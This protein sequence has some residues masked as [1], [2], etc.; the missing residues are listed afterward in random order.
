[1]DAVFRHAMLVLLLLGASQAISEP[2][3]HKRDLNTIGV[4]QNV[5]HPIETVMLDAGNWE[6]IVLKSGKKAF[7]LYTLPECEPCNEMKPDWHALAKRYKKSPN[8]VICEM[9]CDHARDLCA[10]SGVHNFPRAKYYLP[11]TLPVGRDFQE[12]NWFA[13]LATFVRTNMSGL[14]AGESACK[15]DTRDKCSKKELQLIRSYKGLGLPEIKLEMKKLS[16][17]LQQV[18]KSTVMQEINERY[19]IL[20]MLAKL[21]KGKTGKGSVFTQEL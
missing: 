20:R 7:V 21:M 4:R 14:M 17:E 11:E 12:S 6:D 19:Q 9:N 2:E 16:R 18:L 15:L 1:M 5:T 13:N 3:K 10:R 8:V